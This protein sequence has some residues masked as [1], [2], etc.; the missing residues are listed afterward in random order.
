MP[1]Q[2]YSEDMQ[3]SKRAAWERP[4]R[5]YNISPLNNDSY[6]VPNALSSEFVPVPHRDEWERLEDNAISPIDWQF[7]W[8]FTV[9]LKPFLKNAV[10]KVSNP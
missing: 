4:M 5:P 7:K 2:T 3:I 6:L 9:P 10:F 8:R 1:L